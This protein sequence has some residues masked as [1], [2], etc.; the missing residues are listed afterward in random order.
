MAKTTIITGVIIDDQNFS[1]EELC[2]TC[3][4]D[5]TFVIEL[6]EHEVIT[7][8][9]DTAQD[10]QFQANH[11]SR[12]EKALSFY[13]DLG[14]NIPGVSLA[15]ELIDKINEHEHTIRQLKQVYENT[16]KK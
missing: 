11:I 12:I 3:N 9:G 10:W 1:L 7:P 4:T 6:I 13:H 5:Q 15:L 8:K 14:I 16:P 2:R